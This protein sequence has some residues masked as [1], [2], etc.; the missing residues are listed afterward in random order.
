MQSQSTGNLQYEGPVDPTIIGGFSNTFHYKALTLNIFVTYQAGNT[1]R[2]YPAFRTS[3]SD[4]DAMP[5]EFYDRWSVPGDEKYTNVPSILDAFAQSQLNGAY[6]Y[7]NYNYSTQRVAKGDLIRLKTVSLGY[8][9]PQPIARKFGLNNASV[10][11]AATNPWLIY[12]DERLRGQDP[13]FFNSGG[14]AQP[15]Q[16]QI[17]LALKV[18]L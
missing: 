6:P 8:Q 2:L 7:N 13:E 16:K 18:G 5:K 1:I 9:L 11:A 10:T 15:I 4:L 17:T 12:S 14:V 3:Y